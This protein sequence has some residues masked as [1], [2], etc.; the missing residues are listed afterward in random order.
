[1]SVPTLKKS[2]KKPQSHVVS[3]GEM[4][5]LMDVTERRI[6]QL[7]R[8]DAFPH[9]TKGK[10]DLVAAFK[11]MKNKM[12]ASHHGDETERAAKIRLMQSQADLRELELKQK[13]GQL[14]PEEIVIPEMRKMHHA[15][16]TKLM[17]IGN[18]ISLEL[19]HID[20]PPKI[21]SVIDTAIGEAL[22]ELDDT[23]A[24]IMAAAKTKYTDVDHPELFDA[25]PV[26]EQS[27]KQKTTKRK[28]Q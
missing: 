8:T 12:D 13:R 14:I 25:P 20:E 6:N 26:M 1:M 16:K 18:D 17:A 10:Y 9:A 11:W 4:A 27:T 24:R 28:K 7:V 2:P 22:N 19:A 23:G 3:L 5:S 21:K 15:V